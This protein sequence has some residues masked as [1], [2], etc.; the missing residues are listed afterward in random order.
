MD[1]TFSLKWGHLALFSL[2]KDENVLYTYPEHQIAFF[3]KQR[4]LLIYD[5]GKVEIEKFCQGQVALQVYYT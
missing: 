3:Q 1:N 4:S 5:K 2:E